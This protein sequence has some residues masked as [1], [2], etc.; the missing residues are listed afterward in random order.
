MHRRLGPGLLESA[1]AACLSYALVT[2]GIS[3]ER[4]KSLPLEYEG[5]RLDCAYRMDLVVR[6]AVIV[7]VKSV[8]R[9]EAVHDAQMISYLKISGVK[10]GLI[11]N[12]NV[13]NLTH[14][15]LRRKVNAFPA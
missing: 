3:I 15:G 2:R 13:K 5:V 9:L 11:V 7:E 10:V 8:E 12:F 6:R 1:Y 4:Q 14:D